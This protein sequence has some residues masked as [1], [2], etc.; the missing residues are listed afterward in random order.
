MPKQTVLLTGAAGF[1][2]SHAAEH[3]LARG[4]RVVAVDNFCDFYERAWKDLNIRSAGGGEKFDVE[5]IDITDGVAIDKLVAKAKPDVILHL[6]GMAG[7]RPSIEQPAYYARVNVEGTTQMLQAAVNHRVSRF[8]FASSSSVYGN[9]PRV[10]FREDEPVSE[11]ISPYAASKRAGELICYTYWHLYRL[12]VFCLR[13][14]TVYG[15]RLRPDL[16]IHKFTRLISDGQ[17]IPFYGDGT[18]ARDYTYIDDICSGIIAS[19]ER[20]DRYRIYNLGNHRPVQLKEMVAALEKAIGRP[21][22]LDR[23]PMQPGDVEITC[24]DISRAA[25]ELDYHPKTSLQDGLQRFVDW[26]KESGYLY[27]LPTDAPAG[28]GVA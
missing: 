3:L 7:V 20:C 15:P 10:P 19:V 27:R 28:K 21:A 4:Y 8:V 11:P 1:I 23:K 22:I 9:Q 17:P 13:F 18:T 6:A 24:A 14:F 16:A 5:E 2:G 26:F 25:A 12:P